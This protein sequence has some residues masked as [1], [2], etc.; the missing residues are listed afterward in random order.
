MNVEFGRGEYL[1]LEPNTDRERCLLNELG[2]FFV[3]GG[4][5]KVSSLDGGWEWEVSLDEPEAEFSNGHSRKVD[6]D[7]EDY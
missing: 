7:S 6:A 3:C 5:F 4:K 1:K 2:D